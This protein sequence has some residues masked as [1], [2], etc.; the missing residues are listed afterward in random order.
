MGKG[1]LQVFEVSVLLDC[2]TVVRN[3][4]VIEGAFLIAYF[5]VSVVVIEVVL[6]LS[7]NAVKS[8]RAKRGD[9]EEGCSTIQTFV[10]MGKGFLQVFK[11]YVL[12][13]CFTV[14]RNDLVIEGG[15]LI[16]YFLVS[17]TPTSARCAVSKA[18]ALR[19]CK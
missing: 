3:D 4:L 12:L 11:V 2:F 19:N 18:I 14:V 16:A 17:V 7:Q 10:V 6:H 5:L 13:D 8:S 15:F 9:L 1:F